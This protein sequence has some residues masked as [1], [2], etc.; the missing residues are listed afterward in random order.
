[1]F[2]VSIEE[3][4]TLILRLPY[5]NACCEDGNSASFDSHG[6]WWDFEVGGSGNLIIKQ[7]SKGHCAVKTMNLASRMLTKNE[8]Q[9]HEEILNDVRFGHLSVKEVKFYFPQIF[10]Q[11]VIHNNPVD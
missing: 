4:S 9:A 8:T 3:E 1:M 5:Y 10:K 11:L 2:I 6:T 7:D